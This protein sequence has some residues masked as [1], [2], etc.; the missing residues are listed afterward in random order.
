[1]RLRVEWVIERYGPRSIRGR[2]LAG[3]RV[4]KEFE[5]KEEGVRQGGQAVVERGTGLAGAI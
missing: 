4:V 3:A 5:R 1:M 2:S